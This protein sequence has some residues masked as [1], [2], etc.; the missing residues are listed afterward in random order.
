ML[1][2]ERPVAYAAG[3]YG[4]NFDVYDFGSVAIVTG[5][6]GMPERHSKADYKMIK[7]YEQSSLGKTREERSALIQEFI[8]KAKK[9]G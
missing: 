6:R 2:Y 1:N 3:V 9:E 7:Q 8:N 4:W 5:Y